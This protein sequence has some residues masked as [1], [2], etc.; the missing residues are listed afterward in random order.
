VD[1]RQFRV[2]GLRADIPSDLQG[3]PGPRLGYSG[4]IGKRLDLG[5]LRTLAENRPKWSIIMIGA[6]DP[7]ECEKELAELKSMANVYFLGE[8]DPSEVANYISDWDLGMLPYEINVETS[9]ISPLKMYEYLA[10]GLPVVS[11]AIPAAKRK[12]N[13]V[14]IATNSMAFERECESAL[15]QQDQS[16]VL[17]RI[18]EASENTWDHRIVEL[19]DIISRKLAS[20]S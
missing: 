15:S 8:K 20:L 12:K 1:L 16:M 19:S 7:R 13:V 4:L 18:N 10:A 2:A 9:H 3:I 6:E 11:T 17:A 14:A 5:L